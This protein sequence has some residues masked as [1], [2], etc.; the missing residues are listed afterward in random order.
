[1][2]CCIV[3]AFN[4]FSFVKFKYDRLSSVNI[5]QNVR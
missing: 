4:V 1:M 3:S 5:N 2:N